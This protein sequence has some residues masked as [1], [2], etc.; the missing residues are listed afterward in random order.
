MSQ[1]SRTMEQ[2]QDDWNAATQAWASACD[3]W[4]DQTQAMFEQEF[5]HAIDADRRVYELAV[6]ELLIVLNRA[7]DSVN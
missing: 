3:T 7:R 6:E 1:L 2:L 4:N 5:W